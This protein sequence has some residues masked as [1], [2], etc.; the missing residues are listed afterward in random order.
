MASITFEVEVFCF[1][2]TDAE[3]DFFVTFECVCNDAL[4]LVDDFITECIP[5]YGD[6]ALLVDGEC[7]CDDGYMMSLSGQCIVCDEATGEIDGEE[8]ICKEGARNGDFSVKLLI[9]NALTFIT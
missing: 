2:Q 3:N 9:L 8:C 6:T 1:G 7:S 5:C 4:P